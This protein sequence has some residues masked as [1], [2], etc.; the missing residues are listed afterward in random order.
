[1][2]GGIEFV[3]RRAEIDTAECMFLRV[4]GGEEGY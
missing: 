2:G 3:G 1:L 4:G